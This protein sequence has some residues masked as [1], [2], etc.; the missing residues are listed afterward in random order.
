MANTTVLTGLILMT[1]TTA[2][3]SFYGAITANIT[4]VVRPHGAITANTRRATT[5]SI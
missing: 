1:N 3:V 5:T 4:L 2:V